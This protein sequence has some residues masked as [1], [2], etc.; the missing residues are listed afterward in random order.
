MSSGLAYDGQ[1]MLY[2]LDGGQA[3][4][5]QSKLKEVMSEPILKMS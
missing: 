2:L 3:D 5:Y 4:V 1:G